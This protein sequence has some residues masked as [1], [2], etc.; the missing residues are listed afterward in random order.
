[1]FYGAFV[2]V[3]YRSVFR[4][5][6]HWIVQLS[7]C[8]SNLIAKLLSAIGKTKLDSDMSVAYCICLIYDNIETQH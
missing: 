4:A 6:Y 8:K 5:I 2:I 3:S 1:M 7:I